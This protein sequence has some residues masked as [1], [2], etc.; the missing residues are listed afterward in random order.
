MKAVD[1]LWSMLEKKQ[2]AVNIVDQPEKV[3]VQLTMKKIPG[4]KHKNIHLW[5]T[6]PGSWTQNQMNLLLQ[7]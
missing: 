1:V 4:V 3:E 6:L 5:V 7:E 2:S